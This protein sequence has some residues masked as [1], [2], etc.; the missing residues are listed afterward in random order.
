MV[1]ISNAL[2]VFMFS[3]RCS[4]IDINDESALIGRH[5]P[6]RA[7]S[8]RQ[9]QVPHVGGLRRPAKLGH[10]D[11]DASILTVGRLPCRRVQHSRSKPLPSG[12]PASLY[13]ELE[14]MS[15][16]VSGTAA[17]LVATFAFDSG[18]FRF[19]FEQS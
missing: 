13:F 1:V 15:V 16:Q 12:R 8:G 6:H 18:L 9:A 19:S 4:G 11:A 5:D 10:S 17:S 14:W 7:H 3:I 2:S